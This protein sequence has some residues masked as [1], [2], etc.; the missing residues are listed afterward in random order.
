MAGFQGTDHDGAICE[1]NT[2]RAAA[3]ASPPPYCVHIRL[4]C[5]RIVYTDVDTLSCKAI[6]EPHIQSQHVQARSLLQT[7]QAR[8]RRQ[9]ARRLG[10]SRHPVG[11]WRAAYE[12]GGITQLLT[13]LNA[14]GQSPLVPPAV[15]QALRQR[16]THP[17]GLA[18][19]QARWPWRPHAYGLSIAYKPGHR[20]V[21]DPRRAT[22]QVPRQSPSK[23]S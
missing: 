3:A 9:V 13:I 7:R 12:T 22:L 21:R 15:R 19:D 17:E 20:L 1:K 5:P 6:E 11:R 8:T 10:A 23:T 14:P 18:R 4:V 16:L 2:S